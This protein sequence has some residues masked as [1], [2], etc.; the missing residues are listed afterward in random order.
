MII[1]SLGIQLLSYY[2]DYIDFVDIGLNTVV[3]GLPKPLNINNEL[4]Y[5]QTKYNRETELRN[6]NNLEQCYPSN[7]KQK[8]FLDQFILKFRIIQNS[9][10]YDT[11]FMC[12]T[13]SGG[14]GKSNVLQK[15]QHL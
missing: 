13:G 4:S 1:N 14:T 9:E 8:Q 15:V 10:D 2:D 11:I 7:E 12:L 5:E 6:Y 3:F